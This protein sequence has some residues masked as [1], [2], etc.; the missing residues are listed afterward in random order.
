MS[1]KAEKIGVLKQQMKEQK[2]KHKKEMEELKKKIKEKDTL[3]SKTNE[4]LETY[5]TSCSKLKKKTYTITCKL[6]EIYKTDIT[7]YSKEEAVAIAKKINVEDIRNDWVLN[8]RN[9]KIYKK[10]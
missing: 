3:L 5:K 10:R 7:S 9:L 8:D 4:E 2:D 1:G 6:V